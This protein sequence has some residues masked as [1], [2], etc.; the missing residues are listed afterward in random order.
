M[1]KILLFTVLVLFLC[2]S[3]AQKTYVLHYLPTLSYEQAKSYTGYDGIVVD[4][5]VIN[6]SAATLRYMRTVNPDLVIMVYSEKMQWHNPMFPDKP[7]SIKMLATL[8]KYPKWFLCDPTGKN[9]CFWPGT[10]M[11]NCRLDCPRYVINGKSYNYIEFFTERYLRDIIASYKKEGI[12]LD[13]IL[14]DDLLKEISFLSG[15][16]DSNFDGQE[17]EATELNRQ[18]RLGNAY[19]LKKIRQTMGQNFIIIGNGGHGYYLDYCTGKQMENFPE[20]FIGNWS[21]NMTNA[22]GMKMAFFNARIGSEDNWLF[23]ICSSMLLDNVWFSQ[24][25]NTPYDT[26]YDLQLGSAEGNCFQE[27]TGYA[28]KFQNGTIHVDPINNKAWITK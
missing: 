26:R 10:V 6:T 25:Q 11:M 15:G 28:R 1:K 19:F 14:D 17:D 18:W 27:E 3:Q 21:Q 20:T 9:L 4:H 22:S 8:Q 12:K 16:V 13:G 5:E 23:T 7:W 24:G 2:P